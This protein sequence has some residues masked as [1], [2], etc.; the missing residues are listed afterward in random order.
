MSVTPPATAPK[1]S[2]VAAA[3]AQ[4]L[5]TENPLVEAAAQHALTHGN[6][7]S[8][9]QAGGDPFAWTVPGRRLYDDGNRRR[10]WRRRRLVAAAE[11][12][13]T[14]TQVATTAQKAAMAQPAARTEGVMPRAAKR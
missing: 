6:T 8:W 11:R 12:A 7:P 14:A 10:G 1:T 13:A 4:N 3:L 9:N 2:T 5:G